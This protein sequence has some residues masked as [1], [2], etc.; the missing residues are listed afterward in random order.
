MVTGKFFG[1]RTRLVQRSDRPR[2]KIWEFVLKTF[3]NETLNGADF[4]GGGEEGAIDTQL[5]KSQLNPVT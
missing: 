3:L 4:G 1:A 5:P 2:K